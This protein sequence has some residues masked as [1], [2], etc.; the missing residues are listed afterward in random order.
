MDFEKNQDFA[1]SDE[2]K[3]LKKL[4]ND[5]K[6]KYKISSPELLNE[7]DKKEILIPAS[8]FNETLSS[9]ES[10]VKYLRENLNLA[11]KKIS[12]ELNRSEKTISQSYNSAKE[13][14]AE[15]FDIKETKYYIPASILAERKFSVLESIVKFLHEKLNLNYSEIGR[16]LKRDPRTIWTV[17]N[18]SNV[19]G[20]A[21]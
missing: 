6:E 5:F 12:E 16:V 2:L 15:N 1:S 21:G 13:K 7:I 14:L 17:Y 11:N 10:A 18:R 3:L 19:K 9:L 8:I 4:F 20:G